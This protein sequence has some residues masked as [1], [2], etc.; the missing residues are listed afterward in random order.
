MASK[1]VKRG[2][3]EISK[4]KRKRKK[5]NKHNR[6]QTNAENE[7]PTS[8]T[9]IIDTFLHK[10]TVYL[11]L[12]SPLHTYFSIYLYLLKRNKNKIWRWL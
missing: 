5:S 3:S 12:E 10:S 4:I 8:E 2:L 11:H 1:S 9:F 6:P 7:L